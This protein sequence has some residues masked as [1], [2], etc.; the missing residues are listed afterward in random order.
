MSQPPWMPPT[1]YAPPGDFW[2]YYGS[3]PDAALVSARRAGT[4][5]A[6]L[7]VLGVLMGSCV[8]IGITQVTDAQ[9]APIVEQLR[10]QPSMQGPEVTPR[11][12]R[13]I[14]ATFGAFIGVGGLILVALGLLARS[15]RKV[16]LIVALIACG[17]LLAAMALLALSSLAGG[18]AT[19]AG[20][21]AM[22]A[23]P[24]AMFGLAVAWLAQ[25]LRALPHAE[26]QRQAMAAHQQQAMRAYYEQ[27][28]NY[29]PPP[30][31][32]S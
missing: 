1:G 21:A 31:A 17:L 22:L 30:G 9:L 7:G 11:V 25:A 26:A 18:I 24:A 13:T 29:P 6:I 28:Q 27:Q 8:G 19:F 23:L 3:T 5:L 20:T 14:Y 15:G 12:L 4:L 10:Q 2:S 16:W 32:S